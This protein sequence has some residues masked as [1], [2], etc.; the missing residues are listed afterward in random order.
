MQGNENKC[1]KLLNKFLYAVLMNLNKL[2]CKGWYNL[3]VVGKCT[4]PQ[5][6]SAILVANHTSMI[7]PAVL[8]AAVRYRCPTFLMAK[9]YSNIPLLWRLF[10][11]LECI[12]V[13]RDKQ[14]VGATK[15]SIKLLRAGKLLGVFIEG[16]I[17]VDGNRRALKRGAAML[18][19][20]TGAV[21]IPAYINGTEHK[22]RVISDIL[23]RH[24]ARVKF[25]QP[26]K[27]ER[28]SH[29]CDSYDAILKATD[30]IY[31]RIIELRE[32]LESEK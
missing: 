12:P 18:A 2:L 21:I 4:V 31:S 28:N 3:K 26:I 19:M 24:N 17:S 7:D 22:K 11:L 29:K 5:T 10:K 1:Y 6:G 8:V 13:D 9:E 14:D 27:L 16:G 20:R 32:E 30:D 23:F 25:G 15:A